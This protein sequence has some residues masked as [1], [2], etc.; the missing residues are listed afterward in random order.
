MWKSLLPSCGSRGL[1]SR[2]RAQWQV[3]SPTDP[4]HL[5]YIHHFLYQGEV[6]P[7]QLT[8]ELEVGSWRQKLPR[9]DHPP[10][11]Q[12][13]AVKAISAR[14][15]L[16]LPPTPDFCGSLVKIRAGFPKQN[17]NHCAP[18]GSFLTA[19]FRHYFRWP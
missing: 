19:P 1:N 9:T 4:S 7:N 3:P 12:S 10:P 17:K 15:L 13:F 14:A 11:F 6:M 2:P 5:S 8:D 18:V 16:Q